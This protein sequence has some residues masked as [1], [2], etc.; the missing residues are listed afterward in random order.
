MI[1]RKILPFLI[2]FFC[3]FLSLRAVPLAEQFEQVGYLEI[4]NKKHNAVTFDSLYASF[5]IFIEFLQKN[6]AWSQ[7]LYMAK[8]RFVRS[9][10]RSYYST[11]FFGFYD[12]SQNKGRD[13]ISFYYSVHFHE[14]VFLHY[15][16]FRHVPEI[17]NFFEACFQIQEPYGAVFNEAAKAL[18]LE[19]IFYSQYGQPPILFK[20]VKYLP[21]YFATKPHYDGTVFSLFLDSTDNQSLLLSPYKSL[22]I[23]SDF[24]SPSRAFF[25][26]E[27]QSSV[28]LIPGTL[29]A[30]FCIYPT[31]HIVVQNGSVRYATIAFAMRPNWDTQKNE[32]SALPDFK[33]IE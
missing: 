30:D 2:F 23:T 28:L 1:T 9:K 6:P 5:D 24:F 21:S 31:P 3:P 10:A 17:V 7:K 25:R 14:F 18:D 32:F 20:V 19:A 8:E 29:L 15:P 33:K 13:Q 22:F 16:A 4:C 26:N 11:D 27:N 12:E